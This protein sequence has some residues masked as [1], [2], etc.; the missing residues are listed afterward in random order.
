M[1]NKSSIIITAEKFK[2]IMALQDSFFS[3]HTQRTFRLLGQCFPLLTLKVKHQVIPCMEMSTDE[4]GSTISV[5]PIL[6]G[7]VIISYISY[8]ANSYSRR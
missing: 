6:Q 2:N 7:C 4:L 1:E 5:W 8:T 3:L